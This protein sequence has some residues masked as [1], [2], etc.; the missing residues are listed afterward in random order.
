MS[1]YREK[2]LMAYKYLLEVHEELLTRTINVGM[3]GE[4]ADINKT[5]KV[6]DTYDFDIEQFRGT[7]DINLNKLIRF[8]DELE[9]VMNSL[10]NINGIKE[11]ELEDETE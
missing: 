5:F 10:A 4:M 3:T 2:I 7:P 9:D 11:E 6:G 8:Y 1:I